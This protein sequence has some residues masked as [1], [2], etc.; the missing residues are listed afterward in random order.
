[1]AI[2]CL[3]L[4]AALAQA[5]SV[6][7]RVVNSKTNEGIAGIKITIAKSD[8][9][10]PVTTADDGRFSLDNLQDGSYTATYFTNDYW[11]SPSQPTLANEPNRFVQHFQILAAAG[12]VKLEARLIPLARLTGQVVD[13]SRKPI[14]HARI[15]IQ[16][17]GLRLTKAT[18]ADGKFDLHQFILPGAYTLFASPAPPQKPPDPDPET[19]RRL[20]W[21][22]TYYPGVATLEA[23]SKVYLYPGQTTD[24]QIEMVALPAH[25]V[26]GI[27]LDPAGHPAP[28]VKLNL[29][30]GPL[31]EVPLGQIQS[32][33]EGTFEF[34]FVPDGQFVIAAIKP[35]T[36]D[37]NLKAR[38][39]VTISGRD[40]DGVT[41]AL[42]EPF[43]VYGKIAIEAPQAVDP[44]ARPTIVWLRDDWE[45]Y[46]AIPGAQPAPDAQGSFTFRGVYPGIYRISA[47]GPPRNHYLDSIRV[48][49][50]ETTGIAR[51]DA[52][53]PITL[54]YKSNGGALRGSVEKC[55]GGK[56]WIFPS[57]PSLTTRPDLRISATCDANDGYAINSIRPGEYYAIALPAEA[58]WIGELEDALIPQSIRVTIRPTET[59]TADLHQPINP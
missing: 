31:Y 4:A 46:D 29:S 44:S 55:A 16:G 40:L 8:A 47:S 24:V 58:P 6:E 27:L 18:D 57:D 54:S 5:Q 34:P 2:L 50:A 13:R 48:G 53:Q 30:Y 37:F 43:A 41:L 35:E 49:D 3:I 7:G 45:I 25:A 14:P 19:G 51:F 11:P 59:T 21:A 23:A 56:V 42:A 10:Y 20:A 28:G 17:A 22:R 33:P 39:R 9:S 52:P 38:E 36:P 1:M 32:N 12:P 26:R 15:E